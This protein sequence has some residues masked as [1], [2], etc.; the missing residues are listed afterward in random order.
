MQIVKFSYF[1]DFHC[2]GPECLD[3]CCKGWS[4]LLTKKEYLDC[5]KTDFSPKVKSVME[6]AFFRV[7]DK[8]LQNEYYYV[9]MKLNEKDECPFL[10]SDCLCMI[11]K[12]KGEEALSFTCSVFPRLIAAVGDE[13]CICAC[14]ATCSHVVEMLMQHPEGLEL[15]EEEYDG[16]NPYLNRKMYSSAS[17]FKDWEGYPYYWVIK[18]AQIDI[19]QNRSFTIPERMLIL[20]FF[21]QKANDYINKKEGDKIAGL[22][23]MLLDNEMCREIANSLKAPQSDQS[24]ATKSV[25]IIY[26][27]KNSSRRVSD[28]STRLIN[29]FDALA[30]SIDLS[31]GMTDGAISMKFNYDKYVQNVSVYRNI[32]NSRPYII[33]NLLVNLVF[34]QAPDKGIWFN[35]FTTVI[36]YNSL[37]LCIPAL[38]GENRTDRDLALAIS[39]AS[40]MVLN[41]RI[42]DRG[43][44]MSFVDH[45]SYTLPHAAFL[46]S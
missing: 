5:K 6:N 1:D 9:G 23:N 26:K 13:A 25:D 28:A 40:K 29:D 15:V 31:S 42:A 3:S 22:A 46:I 36:F 16:S 35:Y 32:E 20:G 39:R 11:Q 43:V 27:M 41:T 18:N 2:T 19:L 12:E 45:Q 4:I 33:E 24:A 21:C 17:T 44:L 10:D 30:K 37:K 7:R 34:M 14:S 8:N 38:L